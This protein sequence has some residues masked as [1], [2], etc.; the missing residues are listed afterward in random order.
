MRCS[1]GTIKDKGEHITEPP[2]A[3]S[4]TDKEVAGKSRQL[5]YRRGRHVSGSFKR[6]FQLIDL[7]IN[8]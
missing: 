6:N 8:K 5:S 7:G 1:L 4:P 3:S 2:P